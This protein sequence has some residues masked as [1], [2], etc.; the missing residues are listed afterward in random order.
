[1][2]TSNEWMTNTLHSIT[3]RQKTSRQGRT[4]HSSSLSS[5]RELQLYQVIIRILG[6]R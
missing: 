2:A 3:Q 5:T 1:M 6:E 4:E